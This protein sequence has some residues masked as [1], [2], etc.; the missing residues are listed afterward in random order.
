MKTTTREEADTIAAI[1]IRYSRLCARHRCPP[2]ASRM[3]VVLCIER[4]H[5]SGSP[6]RLAELLT[7]PDVSFLHDVEGIINHLDQ[8][9]GQLRDDFAPRYAVAA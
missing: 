4:T 8:G 5:C 6:L 2:L 3:A 1:A 9:T 7:A